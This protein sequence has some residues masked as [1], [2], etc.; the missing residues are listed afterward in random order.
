VPTDNGQIPFGALQGGF[1][2]EESL[3][4]IGRLTYD[5]ATLIGAVSYIFHVS[6]FAN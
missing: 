6:R 2:K 5:G 1:T 3:V 4:F